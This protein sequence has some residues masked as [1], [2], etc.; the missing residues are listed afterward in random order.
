MFER[1][2][3]LFLYSV[4]PVQPCYKQKQI[5]GTGSQA[6]KCFVSLATESLKP[7]RQVD[8]G[9]VQSRQL[10]DNQ[11][12]GYAVCVSESSEVREILKRRRHRKPRCNEVERVLNAI[13]ALSIVIAVSNFSDKFWN[14]L[15][16][17]L[18]RY[19]FWSND[20]LQR[21]SGKSVFLPFISSFFLR[22]PQRRDC[23]G[24][25][26]NGSCP[27]RSDLLKLQ[28]KFGCCH[29]LLRGMRCEL[30]YLD[31]RSVS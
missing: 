6:V 10:A 31:F 29:Y 4:G 17:M 13:K 9:A 26:S 28:P 7:S 1:V 21:L 3:R 5:I 23:C 20:A 11:R 25:R 2:Q 27:G 12:Y 24:Y 8:Y 18:N 30:A 15:R 19:Q 22:K 16:S 14:H